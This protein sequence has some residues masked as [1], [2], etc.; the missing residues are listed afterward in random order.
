MS[1]LRETKKAATRAALAQAAAEI[2][3]RDGAEGLTVAAITSAAGV[4]QRTFHNYF[5]SR[6]EA[7]MESFVE[8]VQA[9]GEQLDDVPADVKLIDAVVDIVVDNLYAGDSEMESIATLFRLGEIIET[10]APAPE[11]RPD[12]ESAFA[13]L[14]PALRQRMPEHNDFEAHVAVRLIIESMAAAVQWYFHSPE[15]RDPAE[16]EKLVRQAAGLLRLD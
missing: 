3:L 5:A 7:L 2:A 12:P 9:L 10:L 8:R 13:S 6:E 16:G 11:E 15:P 1:G 14:L 4:S